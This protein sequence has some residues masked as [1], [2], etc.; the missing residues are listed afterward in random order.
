MHVIIGSHVV[1]L[2]GRFLLIA[3]VI[4]RI[5]L[6]VIVRQM[7]LSNDVSIVQ[8]LAVKLSNTSTM[9][10]PPVA[11]MLSNLVVELTSVVINTD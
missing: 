3:L 2:A 6:N 11:K 8:K 5:T 4:V 10:F 1:S 9:L 7:A